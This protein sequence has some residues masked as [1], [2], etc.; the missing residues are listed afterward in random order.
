ME[1]Q[2]RDAG[3]ASKVSSGL[4][5]S[6]L[7]R[8]VDRLQLAAVPQPDCLALWLASWSRCVKMVTAAEAEGDQEVNFTESFQV[9][10]KTCTWLLHLVRV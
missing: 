8:P 6:G 7:C 10:M 9:S 5:V 1:S 2:H 3:R 4:Q